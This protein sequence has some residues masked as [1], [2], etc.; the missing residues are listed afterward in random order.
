MNNLLQTDEQTINDLALIGRPGKPSVY[1][2]YNKTVTQGGA[3]RL[4]ALFREPMVNEDEINRRSAIYSFFSRQDHHF[5]LD[6]VTMGAVA[7]YME[8]D[9]IR[10]QLQP[11]QGFGQKFRSMV[12]ADA[13]YVFVEDGVLACLRLFRQMEAFAKK[14]E[15]EVR[16]TAYETHYNELTAL[17]N[18]RVYSPLR[19]YLEGREDARPGSAQLADLDK[20]LRF[21]HRQ[22]LLQM[23]HLL[24]EL[25]VY[26]AVGQVARKKG[27]HFAKALPRDSGVLEFK[28]VYHPH[29][30]N[31]IPNNLRLD[32]GHN[33]LFLTGANMAGKSTL[34]KSLGI[35]LYLG[36]MGFPVAAEGLAFSVR[37]GLY[38]NINLSDNLSAGASH[39]YAEVL[40][41]K[42]I[43][44][45]LG[46]GKK[47]FVIFDE[48]FRG[49]NVKDAHD[50]TVAITRAFAR[51]TDSQFIIST[52][53]ME[54]GELLSQEPLSI[55]YQ[56]LPT[57]MK[58]STPVYTR[59]LKKGITD[60]RQG[61]III[62]NEGILEMLDAGIQT[63]TR[64]HVIYN[65]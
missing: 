51:R 25:D 17:L 40:R 64:E 60:D 52:H 26:I 21:D 36:H 3:A 20:L 55:Q 43:A 11:G 34:M 12:A 33:V 46:S 28:K 53:I 15:Y 54:A 4:L 62:R 44:R 57:E 8:N 47:I 10:S 32:K 14:L 42:D 1:E 41:I 7:H 31:A 13:D 30:E 35:A 38:T 22:Q 16:A 65:G 39:Y 2:I 45:E 56:F 63:K 61:M 6:A 24:Y 19:H 18:D 37:D 5:P 49:T 27:F 58:G 9:D 50:A 23:V 59:I 48:L 29:V